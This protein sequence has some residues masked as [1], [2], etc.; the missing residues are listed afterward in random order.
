MTGEEEDLHE[1]R[2]TEDD[3]YEDDQLFHSGYTDID[4]TIWFDLIFSKMML[5]MDEAVKEC[6][7][8]YWSYFIKTESVCSSGIFNWCLEIAIDDI[9]LNNHAGWNFM[10][11]GR[12]YWMGLVLK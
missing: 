7:E 4:S 5:L 2:S 6:L 10:M 1:I 8:E 11:I 9:M 3:I 12:A